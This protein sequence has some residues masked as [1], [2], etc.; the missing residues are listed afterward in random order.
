MSLEAVYRNGH[1]LELPVDDHTGLFDIP[2]LMPVQLPERMRWEAFSGAKGV[3]DRERTGIHFFLDDYMF[4]RVWN[5]PARYAQMLRCF[6]AVMTP[7]FSL[8]TDYPRAVQIY[9]HWR[10]HQLGAYWQRLGMTVIPTICWSDHDSYDWCF[11]GEPMGG[12]VAVSSVGTQKNPQARTLFTD[13]YLEMMR[14]LKPQKV[15]F[16][17]PIPKE[18]A[19]GP[20]EHH[21]TFYTAV[22]AKRRR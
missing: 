14:V 11:D 19:F 8:Y 4:L 16:F 9:N 20:N 7:D 18:C 10:K 13:G 3:E 2:V 15:I 5:D 1:N 12:T 6:G 21:E 22:N 17:G